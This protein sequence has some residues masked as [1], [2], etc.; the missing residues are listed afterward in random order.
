MTRLR[1]A[2]VAIVVVFAAC[3]G[4]PNVGGSCTGAQ[5]CD[6]SLTCSMAIPGGYCTQS[7]PTPGSFDGCPEES[8]CDDVSGIGNTC[9]L[10][11]KT[12]SDCG[13]SDLECNGVSSSNIKGCKP[14]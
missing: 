7:C 12:S 2:L 11:C 3:G 14:N 5:D 6:D 4:A 1:L 8:I 9:V 13:R 10:I